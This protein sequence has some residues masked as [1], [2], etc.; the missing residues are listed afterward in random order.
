MPRLSL[1][2]AAWYR[3]L[4]APNSSFGRT[5]QF[6][7]LKS[8]Y[9]ME[10]GQP[11]GPHGRKWGWLPL[12][13]LGNVGFKDCLRS[14]SSTLYRTEDHHWYPNVLRTVKNTAI[15]QG[16]PEP[17]F[18][19]NFPLCPQGRRNPPIPGR[20]LETSCPSLVWSV[21]C[22]QSIPQS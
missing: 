18:L 8:V 15:L 2:A 16:L 6:G 12:P 14:L 1:W 5:Q 11:E 13:L 19:L 7:P 9:H 22:G 21:Y 4:V 3:P 20:H 17:L 10:Q